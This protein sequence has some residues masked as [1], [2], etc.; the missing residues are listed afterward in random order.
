MVGSA[1]V[2]RLERDGYGNIITRTRAD[3]DLGD[4]AAV[5]L[6]SNPSA[7]PM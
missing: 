7:P 1:I 2:R 4:R 6:S 5:G 3:L